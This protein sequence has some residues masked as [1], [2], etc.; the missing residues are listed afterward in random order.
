MEV[1]R[2]HVVQSIARRNSNIWPIALV[3][4]QLWRTNQRTAWLPP[5]SFYV[6]EIRSMFDLKADFDRCDSHHMC[7]YVCV[8]VCVLICH[9]YTANAYTWHHHHSVNCAPNP[10]L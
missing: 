7:V 5:T 9:I 2:Y 8:C 4:K 6:P 10:Y 3:L 1:F